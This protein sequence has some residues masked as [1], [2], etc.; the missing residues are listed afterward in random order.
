MN[1][2]PVEEEVLDGGPEPERHVVLSVAHRLLSRRRRGLSRLTFDHSFAFIVR[3]CE[4]SRVRQCCYFC[5]ADF[6]SSFACESAVQ[7]PKHCLTWDFSLPLFIVPFL[8][9]SAVFWTPATLL[10]VFSHH[11]WRHG[12]PPNASWETVSRKLANAEFR[13][14]CWIS[15]FHKISAFSP[16]DTEGSRKMWNYRTGRNYD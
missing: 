6:Q 9:S 14:L 10:S 3:A 16:H 8:P 1:V 11:R 5:T 2:E 7:K 13:L 4:K 12:S 15:R